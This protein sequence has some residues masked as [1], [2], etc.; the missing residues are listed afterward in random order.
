MLN[1]LKFESTI[2]S[3][4]VWSSHF[5]VAIVYFGCHFNFH[6]FARK[7]AYFEN[8]L[9]QKLLLLNRTSMCVST[10]FVLSFP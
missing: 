4:G 7:H 2:T 8:I 3:T 9:M 1:P 10:C 6:Y 5:Q